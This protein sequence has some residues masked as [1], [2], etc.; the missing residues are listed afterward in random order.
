M[1][2]TIILIII[3]LLGISSYY[4]GIKKS[5]ALEKSKKLH[6]TPIYH[7]ALLAINSSVA[8]ILFIII[9]VLC[10]KN[11]YTGLSSS[12]ADFNKP[13]ALYELEG[14]TT[15]NPGQCE[16]HEVKS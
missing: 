11:I 4:A 7:G 16:Y 3:A 13:F 2:I 10:E 9:W 12:I 14:V 8:S 15:F 1:N 5:L 6:S